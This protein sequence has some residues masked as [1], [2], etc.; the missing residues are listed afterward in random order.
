[1]NTFCLKNKIKIYLTSEYKHLKIIMYSMKTAFILRVA[2]DLTFFIFL[3][4]T[5]AVI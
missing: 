2:N 3:K 1:M 5:N 4:I